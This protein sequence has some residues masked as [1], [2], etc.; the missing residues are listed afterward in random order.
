M[1]QF[2]LRLYAEL[3]DFIP[4][5]NR[6]KSHL[7]TCDDH[8]TIKHII[9]SLGIPHTEI[10]IILANGNSVD[11]AYIPKSGDYIS[12]YPVFEALDIS[13]LLKIRKTVLRKPAFVLDT[14]LGKLATYLRM[15]GLDSIYN[16]SAS[17]DE[18]AH[19]S[20]SQNRIL[21]TKDR[22]LLKR[23]I[24][25]HG[26]IVR[27][28]FPKDQLIEVIHKFDLKRQLRPFTICLRCNGALVQVDKSKV[29]E[30]LEESTLK[31]YDEFWFCIGCGKLYW[32]GSHYQSM[33]LF[34]DTWV[35]NCE[36]DQ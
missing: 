23:K 10:E 30:L 31:Y 22:G 21:L 20:S 7:I 28:I 29:S 34:L 19:I 17:D 18:L 4:I 3:N 5:Q 2:T 33:R 32:K 35:M 11:Y 25:T 14:H 6:H 16:N 24:I 36:N 8:C 12:V 27:N 1:T 26:Y 15:V 13:P 9:E